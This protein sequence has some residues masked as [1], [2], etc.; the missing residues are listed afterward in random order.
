MGFTNFSG[1]SGMAM[2]ILTKQGQVMTHL[3]HTNPNG[4][5]IV[6]TSAEANAHMYR[7]NSAEWSALSRLSGFYTMLSSRWDF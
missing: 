6:E 4:L 5:E 7:L 3:R 2:L 1:N